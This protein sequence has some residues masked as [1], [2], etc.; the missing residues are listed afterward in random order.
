MQIIPDHHGHVITPAAIV[1]DFDQRINA[2]IAAA[3]DDAHQNRL[4]ALKLA[5]KRGLDSLP[6]DEIESATRRF[7][8]ELESEGVL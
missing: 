7:L 6:D 1:S 2:A 8:E 4:A 3:D 5:F